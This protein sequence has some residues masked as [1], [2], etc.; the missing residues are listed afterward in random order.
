MIAEQNEVVALITREQGKP[1]VE[2]LTSE[3]VSVIDTLAYYAE[4][5]P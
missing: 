4:H 5:A 2:A 1:T 3:V